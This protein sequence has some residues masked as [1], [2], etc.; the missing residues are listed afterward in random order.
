M[1]VKLNTNEVSAGSH[2]NKAFFLRLKDDRDVSKRSDGKGHTGTRASLFSAFS[3]DICTRVA[4]EPYNAMLRTHTAHA[5]AGQSMSLLIFSKKV[6]HVLI[7][8]KNAGAM[9]L[10]TATFRF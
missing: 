6:A 4:C 8:N 3:C 7:K 1:C 5:H 9:T 2:N 10:K